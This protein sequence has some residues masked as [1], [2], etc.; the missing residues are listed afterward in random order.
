MKKKHFDNING[1]DV[2][3]IAVIKLVSLKGKDEE[4]CGL[5][6]RYQQ[7]SGKDS[8]HMI[9]LDERLVKM[10]ENECRLNLLM[11]MFD[12]CPNFKDSFDNEMFL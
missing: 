6:N 10:R 4:I 2:L 7:L 12:G 11:G 3:D 8:S 5:L 9:L 1:L